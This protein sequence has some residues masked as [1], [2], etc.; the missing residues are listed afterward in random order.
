MRRILAILK[1]VEQSVIGIA[2]VAQRQAIFKSE[3]GF[4]G[5]SVV[6]ITLNQAPVCLRWNNL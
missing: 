1:S 3:L 5:K 2:K 6:Q 4:E